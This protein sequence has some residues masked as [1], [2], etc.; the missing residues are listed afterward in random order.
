MMSKNLVCMFVVLLSFCGCQDEVELT[1]KIE[2]THQLAGYWVRLNDKYEGM[3]I[4]IERITAYRVIKDVSV[5]EQLSQ[6]TVV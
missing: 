3:V 4:E 5:F 2:K 1:K 6:R